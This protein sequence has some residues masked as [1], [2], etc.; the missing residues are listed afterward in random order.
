MTWIPTAKEIEAVLALPGPVRY[1]HFI[2]RVA[3]TQRI[4]SLEHDGW[5]L[6]GDDKGQECIP[7]WPHAKYAELCANGI[8]AGFQPQSIDIDAW[9]NKWIPGIE[10]DRRLIAVFPTP[11]RRGIPVQPRRLE[12]D[13]REELSKYE[14]DDKHTQEGTP[15]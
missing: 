3:D 7:V 9:L 11:E 10:K 15:E 5:A 8:W 13:L 14:W 1:A 12:A 2:K 4:W 6:L